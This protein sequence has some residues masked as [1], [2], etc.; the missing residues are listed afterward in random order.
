M[1]EYTDK[2]FANDPI[3]FDL[4]QRENKKQIRKWG[5]QVHSGFEWLTYTTE[6]LGELAQAISEFEYR[7]GSRENVVKEAIQTATLALKIAEMYMGA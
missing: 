5:I 6:E 3:L 4:L 2:C 1:R 7:D